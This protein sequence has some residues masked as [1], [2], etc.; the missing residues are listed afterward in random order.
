MSDR[1]MALAAAL[2]AVAYALV[3][4]AAAR[5]GV[6][7]PIAQELPTVVQGVA[8]KTRK[9]RRRPSAYNRQW[10]KCRQEV[11]KKARLKSGAYRK[12]WS[13]A[14]VMREAHAL[15]RRRMK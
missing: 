2:R 14:R 7:G 4:G 6:P 5:A 1:D 13:N 10:A 15:C 12:G 8:E 11:E 3:V 9:R